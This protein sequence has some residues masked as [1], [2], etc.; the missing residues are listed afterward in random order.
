[1]YVP[2][3]IQLLEPCVCVRTR[4]YFWRRL[5]ACVAVYR[6]GRSKVSKLALRMARR[7]VWQ[8]VVLM[9]RGGKIPIVCRGQT[10]Y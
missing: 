8:P 7:G 1:M 3:C 6:A 5:V 9:E 4:A 10:R 2:G